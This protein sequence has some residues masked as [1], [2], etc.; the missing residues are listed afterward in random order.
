MTMRFDVLTLFPGFFD[1]PLAAA[2]LG[3][4]RERGLIEFAA[5][6]LRDFATGRHR[7]ADDSPYGGGEGMVMK[8]EPLAAGIEFLRANSPGA[9][10]VLL[11]PQ[12]KR[13]DQDVAERYAHLPGLVL[14]CGRY[15]G[16]DARVVPLVDE[17][18][19]V[20]DFVLAGGEAAALVVIEAVARLVPGVVGNEDSV[21]NDSFPHRLKYPQ[22]TRPRE[23]RGQAV[24]DVLLSGDHDAIDAWRRRESLKRT[25]ELRPDLLEKFPPD[26][27]E[28]EVLRGMGRKKP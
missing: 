23:F 8:P 13:F 1:S 17:E 26:E 3:K 12:G 16:V 6:D 11:T 7:Q 25:L 9:P 15:E 18:L 5:T 21:V 4:A 27:E 24:P 10:V 28:A 22:Y 14:V 19:S 2:L 20:G